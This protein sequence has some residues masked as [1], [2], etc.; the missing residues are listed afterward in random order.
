MF[1][2]RDE[3]DF[4]RE[5]DELDEENRVNREQAFDDFNAFDPKRFI[6]QR[7]GRAA[8]PNPDPANL[9]T[10]PQLAESYRWAQGQVDD[11]QLPARRGAVEPEPT[12]RRGRSQ[13]RRNSLAS[14]HRH[15]P[16]EQREREQDRRE[17]GLIGTALRVEPGMQLLVL[18]GGCFGLMFLIGACGLV[19]WF[20][21]RLGGG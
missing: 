8:P 1:D 10:D 13:I 16:L 7:R 9:P 15:D 19:V 6:Q 18:S 21:Q 12:R 17:P 14:R 5:M 4:N 2:H 20:A 11:L 3:D